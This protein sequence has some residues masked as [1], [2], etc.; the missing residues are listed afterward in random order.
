M[1]KIVCFGELMLRLNPAGYL[2]FEQ[3]NHF[4]A[5]FGGGE[6]N[7]AVSLAHFGMDAAF[8]SKFPKHS[9]GDM[10]IR[11]LRVEDVK[12]DKIVRGGERMGIY[13]LEKGASLRASAVT[14]DR[15]GSS[16]AMSGIDDYDWNVILPQ[17]DSITHGNAFF[18]TGITPAVGENLPGILRDALEVCRSRKIRTYC[19]L[20]YR[21]ALWTTE[22]AGSVL[23]GLLPYTDVCVA[24]EEHAEQLFGITT[25]FT[26]QN[27]RIR[28]IA[29]KMCAKFGHSRVVMTMRRSL[30]ADDNEV[31][32]ATLNA[33]TGEF[34]VSRTYPVHIIDRVGGGDSFGGG[35]IYSLLSGK[36]TQAAVEFAVAASALKHSIGGD[37]N[38]VT[39]PEV[40]KLAGG[41]GS[42]RI[43]R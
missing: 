27:D 35:L 18:W 39:V 38:M 41:D 43:Q 19:D 7:V 15:R 17:D 9:I 30:S 20:N 42:G 11:S 10:A 32:A 3:A 31:S 23:R 25:A 6:A 14:Y 36:D 16:F 26:E 37:Y 21:A 8:V 28:D 22:K 33:K 12:T 4:E 40:E 13:Y 34:T 2:R 1:S 5:S 29:E 24:N